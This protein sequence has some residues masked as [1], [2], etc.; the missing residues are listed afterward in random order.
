MT[1]RNTIGQA[2]LPG[3]RLA[4]NTLF[5]LIGFA[6]P[7]VVALFSIPALVKGLGTERFGV[8][9]LSWM[10]VGYFG[11]LDMGT[12]RATTK[13][14]ADYAARGDT[15]ALARLVWSSTILL[16]CLGTVGGILLAILNPLLVTCVLKVPA[17]LTGETISSFF[18]LAVAIPFVLG[19]AGMRGVLEA[20]QRF[21]LI[22]AVKIPVSSAS[23]CAPLLVL[24]FSH[25]LFPI[26]TLLLLVRILEF[27]AYSFFCLQAI[28]GMTRPQWPNRA[29]A[30]K[31]LGFGKWLTVS[32]IIG[33]F[34]SYMDRFLVGMLMTISAV[35]Y[36]ATPYDMVMK[37]G[38]I[39]SSVLGVI[40]PELSAMLVSGP[41]RFVFLYE[42]SLKYIMFISAPVTLAIIVL[43]GPLME[44]WLGRDFAMHSTLVLQILA[45]GIFVNS[46]AQVPYTA[47][48]ALGRPDMTAK[49]H[50][51]EL[52]FYLV[53]A[54]ALII[55]MG[56]V[57]AA[58]AWLLRVAVDAVLLF[59]FAHH[60]MPSTDR[61]IGRSIVTTV[62]VAALLILSLCLATIL[63]DL[64]LKL[65]LAVVFISALLAFFWCVSL[66]A[67]E[68]RKIMFVST[69][70]A[71]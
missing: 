7:I 48:Q 60:A 45:V 9:T 66:D 43:A 25:S 54:A 58:V 42:Q 14:A 44:L 6:A 71:R 27:S 5:N 62:G 63:H 33:P 19:T 32:N 59:R 64:M 36:Y 40:F 23:F 3:R 70:H 16:F 13:F 18:V 2:A 17:F 57:G 56:I 20:Q 26:T 4:R 51:L 39:S 50:L 52:P 31:L 47:I 22:N 41:G 65:L 28:P 53:V 34:M 38:I 21:G 69:Y 24:P 12:G 15:A 11:F 10:V 1:E 49:L 68:K 46:A 30:K 29:D 35:A 61:R 67:E 8:L 55:R 37:L